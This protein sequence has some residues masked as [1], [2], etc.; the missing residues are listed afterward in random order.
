M[1]GRS[2]VRCAAYRWTAGWFGWAPGISRA[3][4][5]SGAKSRRRRGNGPASRRSTVRPASSLK[6]AANAA[7]EA[8]APT[9][10]TSADVRSAV[11]PMGTAG[12]RRDAVGGEPPQSRAKRLGGALPGAALPETEAVGQVIGEARDRPGQDRKTGRLRRCSSSG[13][14]RA[15]AA[16]GILSRG[17]AAASGRA[18]G[19]QIRATAR[20]SC[21]PASKVPPPLSLTAVVPVGHGR[22]SD[23]Y[24]S[25]GRSGPPT[26]WRYRSTWA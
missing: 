17:T 26:L 1:Q 12:R 6:R 23:Q 4:S 13:G 24:S 19:H 2:G 5:S 3:S 11:S 14:R 7:P 16:S 10:I 22:R 21:S 8:P 9:T 18:S 25:S 15:A 20:P